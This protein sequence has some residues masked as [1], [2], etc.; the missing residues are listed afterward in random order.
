MK[1][2][3]IGAGKVGTALTKVLCAQ[4]S[5]RSVIVIDQ[6]GTSLQA[7]EDEINDKKLRTFRVGIEKELSI[8]GLI[9]GHDC[10]ISALPY[11]FNARI[12][13]LAVKNGINF[14]DFGAND[15]TLEK[16]MELNQLA[17][18]KEL[19][20]IPNCGVAP[21]L[22][23]IMALHAFEDFDSVD[24]IK[25]RAA[26]L[27][28]DPHPPLNYQ[29]SFS[30]SGLISEYLGEALIIKDGK[31][32][33]VNALDG[34]E[35]I[36]LKN[37]VDLG[38]LEAFYT[39]GQITTLAHQLEGKVKNL[40]FKTIRYA[41]HRNIIKSLFDLGFDSDGLIDIR[42]SLSYRNLLIRQL[43]RKLPQ[44]APDISLIKVKVTG[45]KDGKNTKRV[46]EIVERF[47]DELQISA[48]MLT[49]VVPVVVMTQLM[50][51]N[52]LE[53]NFGVHPPELAVPKKEFIDRVIAE[54]INLSITDDVLEM[55]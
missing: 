53:S 45:V 30:P 6:N 40:E 24:D 27:P 12:A 42:S 17:F 34:L 28:V 8:S 33:S 5:V 46:Y 20:I 9:K 54:N 36:E 2:A 39:S 32:E 3:I 41:G 13:K 26:G 10:L 51:E 16:Q 21:G 52:K 55:A 29:L 19:H 15:A 1:L 38:E 4:E 11:E 31:I 14:I 44:G 48:M 35:P 49:T 7:L 43:L 25:I 47:N 37:N 50:A 18:E 22:V 23:N